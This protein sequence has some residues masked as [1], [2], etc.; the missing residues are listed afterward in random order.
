MGSIFL[1]GLQSPQGLSEEIN[2]HDQRRS[3]PAN[4]LGEGMS[5]SVAIVGAGMAGVSAAQMLTS[6]GIAVEVFDKS[7]GSGGRMASKRIGDSEMLPVDIGTQSFKA[8]SDGFKKALQLWQ[9]Q[10]WAKPWNPVTYRHRQGALL[11][12][13]KA[14]QGWLGY[15]RMSALTRKLLGDTRLR[16]SIQITAL[17]P[18]AGRWRLQDR[19]GA[20]YGPYSHLIITAPA[21]QASRLL[22]PVP[23]LADAASQRP[24]LPTWV[25]VLTLASPLAVAFDRLLSSSAALDSAVRHSAKPGREGAQ[26]VW[27]LQASASWSLNHTETPAEQIIEQLSAAFAGML[28][29]PLPAVVVSLA[30]RWLFAQADNASPALLA[31]R[32]ATLFAGGDWCA[33]GGVEGAWLSGRRMAERLLAGL[34]E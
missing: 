21:P 14:E 23:E 18:Q 27:V 17:L 9:Q 20:H 13:H 3:C 8:C 6:K 34:G 7:R 29:S 32:A 28:G 2:G 30:H 15:P 12:Y 33:C 26:E 4:L 1:I 22:A 16:S 10:G 19:T 31:N 24:M 25:V 5:V 11:R